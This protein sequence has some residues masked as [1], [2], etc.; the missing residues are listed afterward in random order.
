MRYTISLFILLLFI[1]CLLVQLAEAMAGYS[2]LFTEYVARRANKP[3]SIINVSFFPNPSASPPHEATHSGALLDIVFHS[4]RLV[5][6]DLVALAQGSRKRIETKHAV[7]HPLDAYLVLIH[8]DS[9]VSTNS[10]S[11]QSCSWTY[12]RCHKVKKQ[13]HKCHKFL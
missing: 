12:N 11:C 7:Q 3:I 8:A 2:R 5:H 9:V 6:Q 10:T 4:R 1:R 13:K